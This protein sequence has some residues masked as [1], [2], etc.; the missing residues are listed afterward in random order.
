LWC[1]I[2]FYVV[3]LAV[4]WGFYTRRGGLLYEVERRK[5]LAPVHP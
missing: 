2:A 5:M 4:T 1:F 3:R